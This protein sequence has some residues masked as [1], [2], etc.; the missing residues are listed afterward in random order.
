MENVETSTVTEIA[1]VAKRLHLLA[2]ELDDTEL[3]KARMLYG[4]LERRVDRV[5]LNILWT[6]VERLELLARAASWE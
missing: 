5:T 1:N 3:S 4:W 6:E 2:Q